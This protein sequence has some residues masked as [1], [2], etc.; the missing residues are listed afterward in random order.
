MSNLKLAITVVISLCLVAML[1]GF[2]LQSYYEL[3]LANFSEPPQLQPSALQTNDCPVVEPQIQK[4]TNLLLEAPLGW[5]SPPPRW[6]QDL[7]PHVV[8]HF[9]MFP[10]LR[11]LVPYPNSKSNNNRT[12]R[13]L[14][15]LPWFS[16]L[17][18]ARAVCTLHILQTQFAIPNDVTLLLYAGTHMG[19]VGRTR[20]THI[21]WDDDV[22][23]VVNV[24]EFIK[25]QNVLLPRGKGRDTCHAIHGTSDAATTETKL[26]VRL[27]YNAL[28]VWITYRDEHDPNMSPFE[29]QP[30]GRPWKAPFLDI[31]SYHQE[32]SKVFELLETWAI[33]DV[34]AGKFNETSMVRL[35]FPMTTFFPT[36]TYYFAGIW[37]SGPNNA[38]IRRRY[39][40]T[41]CVSSTWSHRLDVD[42]GLRM[43]E[44]FG[45][46]RL[47][48]CRLATRFPFRQFAGSISNGH[49]LWQPVAQVQQQQRGTISCGGHTAPTCGEC[50][51]SPGLC[52]GACQWDE[53][54]EMC[55]PT[56]PN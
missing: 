15:Y 23:L 6:I 2:F 33:D 7:C 11:D 44:T 20:T 21:P 36:T 31:F 38:S 40:A 55:R 10:G 45:T 30:L 18:H 14:R 12:N 41:A 34:A 51:S 54:N 32:G 22:D 56:L 27:N 9:D 3:S 28:K 25:L 42:E 50:G 19:A 5:S 46:D 1:Q 24:S 52:H 17:Y 26:C 35:K 49:T 47:D 29:E 43:A 13:N 4:L 8:Q 39:D 48:C 16:T 37:M 53:D